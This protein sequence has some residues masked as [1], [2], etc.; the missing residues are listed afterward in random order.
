V[1]RRPSEGKISDSRAQAKAKVVSDGSPAGSEAPTPLMV[2]RC[3][4]VS[5]LSILMDYLKE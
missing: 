2:A 5:V 3:N 1:A 4:A